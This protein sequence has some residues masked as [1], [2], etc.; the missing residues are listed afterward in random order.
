MRRGQGKARTLVTKARQGKDLRSKD[1]GQQ[2]P[3]IVSILMLEDHGQ[4]RP[5][6]AS[7]IIFFIKFNTPQRNVLVN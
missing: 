3:V 1:Q 2:R 5:V 7:N 4:Q 6:L